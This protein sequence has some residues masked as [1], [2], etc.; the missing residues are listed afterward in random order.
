LSP[1][2]I[3]GPLYDHEKNAVSPEA[4]FIALVLSTVTEANSCPSRFSSE[5]GKCS[6][7]YA[8]EEVLEACFADL[9]KG[10]VFD[11]QVM[12]GTSKPCIRATR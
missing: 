9:L 7:P 1:S 12:I 3:A 6:E 5:Q 2:V 10:L 11:D 8:R 4:V